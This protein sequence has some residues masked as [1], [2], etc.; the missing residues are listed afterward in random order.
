[1][2]RICA[3]ERSTDRL[4]GVPRY[5][6]HAV[7]L[8]VG[9]VERT[10]AVAC[11]LVVR[12]FALLYSRWTDKVNDPILQL[13]RRLFGYQSLRPGQREAIES[14][15][16]GR[17][18]LVVM[19]TGAGKSA[20]FELAGK[21]LGGPAVVISPLI[22]LQRDQLAALKARGHLVAIALNS[23]ETSRERREILDHDTTGAATRPDFVFL[24]PEQVANREVLK[25]LSD[26]RPAMVAVDEAHLISR[27]G[28]DFRPEYL[29]I[30]S[31]VEAMGRPIVLALTATAAPSVREE[32]VQRLARSEEHTSE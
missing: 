19:S 18:T 13:A 32:I 29:R 23:A 12:A 10:R 30:A 26:L 25:W 16:R 7:T 6:E 15:R 31:A 27:W 14:V 21:L 5:R 8:G 28:P 22:A 9:G 3:N 11:N 17:D 4:P 24:G 1:M 2:R 20:I